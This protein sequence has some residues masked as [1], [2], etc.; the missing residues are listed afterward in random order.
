ML[1]VLCTILITNS[2]VNKSTQA[3][4]N[5]P[6]PAQIVQRQTSPATKNQ[7]QGKLVFIR[8]DNL[9]LLDNGIEKQLINDAIST[10]IPYWTG[11]SELWYSNPQ[12]SPDGNKIAYL[13]NTTTDSRTLVISDTNGKNVKQLANDVE[14]TIPI[15]QWSNNSQK[16]YYPSSEGMEMIAVISVD[17]A[18]SEKEKHGQFALKSGCGGRSSD[19]A[20]HISAAE[21]ITSVGGGVQIFNLSPRNDY[22]VHTTACTGTGLGIFEL[23]TKQDRKLDDKAMRAVISPNGQ[24]VAAIL[25]N[26]ILIF[27]AST[28]KVQKTYQVSEKPL[29]LL[30][31]EKENAIYYSTSKLVK[32][33]NYDD[34]L[35]LDVLGSS[36]AS[37][38]VNNASLWK[39]LLDSEKSEKIIDFD[40]HNVKP[41]FSKDQKLLM[42]VVENAN[43]LFEYVKQQKTKENMASYY[44][45]VKIS[46][47]DLLNQTS[48]I[49][50]DKAQQSFYFFE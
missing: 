47:V 15:I 2:Q 37:Y 34:Q 36:P 7:L 20:D 35:A 12:I 46:E 17:V 5:T 49:I 39:L 32:T 1:I 24:R 3:D 29:I 9:W 14:W 30:W 42:V 18:T 4:K 33:L 23:S 44:P 50:V 48:N 31:G 38:R 25:D 28:G 27:E 21:N 26:N 45:K 16:I 11:L 10:E 6:S 13:K 40:A 8:N 41:I 43:S 19:P 22:I